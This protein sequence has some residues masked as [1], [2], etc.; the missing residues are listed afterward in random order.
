M[1]TFLS[2]H[3]L[4]HSKNGN[5]SFIVSVSISLCGILVCTKFHSTKSLCNIHT[6]KLKNMST[7]SNTFS[8]KGWA[9]EYEGILKHISGISYCLYF[10]KIICTTLYMCHQRNVWIKILLY[11]KPSITKQRMNR[12]IIGL[13]ENCDHLVV[14]TVVKW[15]FNISFVMWVK[16]R[17]CDFTF[18]NIYAC[19]ECIMRVTKNAFNILV[20]KPEGQ[21]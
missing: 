15:L 7:K 5:G 14:R 21:K 16:L 3:L 11:Q 19:S 4:R 10:N 12:L 17:F 18:F 13:Y 9:N 1:R 2:L 6:N 8:V 20:G